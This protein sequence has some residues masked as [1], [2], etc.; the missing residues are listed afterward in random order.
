MAHANPA[1]EREKWQMVMV[2]PHVVVWL[3]SAGLVMPK[4][5][6][7]SHR[8]LLRFFHNSASTARV[9]QPLRCVRKSVSVHARPVLHI[10]ERCARDADSAGRDC[11]SDDVTLRESK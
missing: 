5:E 6:F 1:L 4:S 11:T 2:K 3:G 10:V 8:C 9:A 7:E